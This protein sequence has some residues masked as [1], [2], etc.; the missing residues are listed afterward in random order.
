M[1]IPLIGVVS[2]PY[3]LVF[4]WRQLESAFF[5]AATSVAALFDF[6]PKIILMRKKR[7]NEKSIVFY[8][9]KRS[10]SLSLRRINFL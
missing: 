3:S 2:Y 4:V 5:G 8:F 1:L 9:V 6:I 7:K 10:D